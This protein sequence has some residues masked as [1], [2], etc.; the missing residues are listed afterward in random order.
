[1]GADVVQMR[2]LRHDKHFCRLPARDCGH[3][4]GQSWPGVEIT[5]EKLGAFFTN[6][7]GNVADFIDTVA[8]TE[9]K[10]GIATRIM[11]S[12][13]EREVLLEMIAKMEAEDVGNFFK[14]I[15]EIAPVLNEMGNM[16]NLP[17]DRSTT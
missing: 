12:I 8:A 15:A 17:P 2:G 7:V 3:C 14:F 10:T 11:A 4:A 1:M 16:M 9:E 13:D 6:F 5:A